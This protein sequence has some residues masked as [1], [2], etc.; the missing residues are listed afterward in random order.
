MRMRVHKMWNSLEDS[1][2]QELA[3]SMKRRMRAVLESNGDVTDY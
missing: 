2:L 3:S 1:Y